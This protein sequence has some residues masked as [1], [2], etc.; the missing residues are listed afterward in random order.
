MAL[1]AHQAQGSYST[2]SL[3]AKA[4]T[5]E[6]RWRSFVAFQFIGRKDKFIPLKLRFHFRDE[7][8]ILP[9]RKAFKVSSFKGNAQNDEREGR[10]SGS[11]FRKAPVQLSAQQEREEILSDSHDVQ[12]HPLSYAPE[13]REETTAGSLAIQEVFRKWL[14]MLRMQTSSLRMDGNFHGEPAENV[15]SEGQHVTMRM[16]AVNMLKVALVHFLRLDA[17]ISIPLLILGCVD[18]VS[19]AWAGSIS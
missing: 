13:G 1:L 8:I 5:H 15:T 18:S 19:P 10:D 9:K 14:I 16:R 6:V 4:L 11:K 7:P 12:K 17:A 3:R 2:H